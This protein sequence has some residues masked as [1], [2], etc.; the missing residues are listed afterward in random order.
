M[1][2]DLQLTW[3]VLCVA[4]RFLSGPSDVTEKLLNK[5]IELKVPATFF[6]NGNYGKPQSCILGRSLLTRMTFPPAEERCI[7]NYAGVIQR[8]STSGITL[9]HHTW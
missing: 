2:H 8:A 7:Y 1:V 9:G 4:A 3:C 6:I 5:L